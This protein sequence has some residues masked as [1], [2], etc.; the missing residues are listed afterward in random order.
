MLI[1]EEEKTLTQS[2][3][4]LSRAAS[5]RRL[6][7]GRNEERE[8]EINEKINEECGKQERRQKSEKMNKKCK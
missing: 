6:I 1:K 5:N 3:S 8:K 7:S 2:R 4:P